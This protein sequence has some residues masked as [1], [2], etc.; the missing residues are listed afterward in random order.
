MIP[1]FT[2][3]KDDCFSACIASVLDIP[4]ADVPHFKNEAEAAGDPD[5]EEFYELAQEFLARHNKRW[6]VINIPCE[7]FND[8]LFAMSRNRDQY[9]IA[10]GCTKEGHPHA[11]IC[12]G[13]ECVHEPGGGLYP[14]VDPMELDGI[15]CVV[16]WI[17]V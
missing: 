6:I 16:A 10:G 7:Y 5:G 2:Q 8:A 11:V 17:I 15:P 12:K 3:E 9:W 13:G 14:I 4:R 1:A